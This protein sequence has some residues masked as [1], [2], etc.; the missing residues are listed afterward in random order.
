[1]NPEAPRRWCVY[2]LVGDKWQVSIVGAQ[3]TSLELDPPSDPAKR[4]RAIGVAGVDGSG[5]LAPASILAIE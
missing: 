2:Q 5:V 3:T 1:P 4:V